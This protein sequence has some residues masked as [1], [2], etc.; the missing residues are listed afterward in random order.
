MYE[1]PELTLVGEVPAVVLG[2]I[3]FVGDNEGEAQETAEGLVHG[4]DD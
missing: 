2:S 1:K 4:L 3:N